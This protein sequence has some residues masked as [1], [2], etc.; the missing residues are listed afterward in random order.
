MEG[1]GC[2]RKTGQGAVGER[3]T[4]GK[5]RVRER[6]NVSDP[7]YLYRNPDPN[8]SIPV[9]GS[10][11]SRIP[12]PHQRIKVFLTQKLFLSARKYDPGC[13]SQIPNPDFFPSWI[14]GKRLRD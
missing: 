1:K 9:P 8:F 5:E 6:S 10:K 4:K 2:E 7:G 3:E 11:R 12:D 13:S 14:P